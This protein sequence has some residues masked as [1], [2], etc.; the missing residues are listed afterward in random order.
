MK[1]DLN[2]GHFWSLEPRPVGSAIWP[3]M[4]GHLT[5]YGASRYVFLPVGYFCPHILVRGSGTVRT[6][7]GDFPVR[8]GDMFTLWAGRNI[9]YF[10]DPGDPWQ[11]Y[12]IHLEGPG[13][14][15]FVRGCGFEADRLVQRPADSVAARRLFAQIYTAYSRRDISEA[16][17]IIAWLYEL[18]G[19]CGQ[20]G[21]GREESAKDSRQLI[22]EQAVALAD[23]ML[24]TGINVSQI[25]QTLGV[26]RTTLFRAFAASGMENPV[27]YLGQLRIERAKQILRQTDEKLSVVAS[28]CGFS[29]E[30]YFIRRFCQ[31]VGMSPTEYR[32]RV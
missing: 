23:A 13:T 20:W 17:K 24:H 4:V 2:K 32:R 14:E 19:V 11:Y 22:A 30:K 28:A 10:E 8:V 25:A 7:E 27:E 26:C 5:G 12:W 3:K 16:A 6:D 31:H 18:A 9:E 21:R 1:K 15:E 29:G